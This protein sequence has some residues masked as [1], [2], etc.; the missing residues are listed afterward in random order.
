M[1]ERFQCGLECEMGRKRARKV[2]ATG[3]AETAKA[4]RLELFLQDHERLEAQ[5][6]KRGLNKASTAR[7]VI[8]EWLEEQEKRELTTRGANMV[9][10]IGTINDGDTVLFQDMPMSF[11]PTGGVLKGFQGEFYVPQGGAYVSPGKSF[12]LTVSDGRTGQI[13]IKSTHL[14]SNQGQRVVF[15]TQGQFE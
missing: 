7:M 8:L 10:D 3:Q 1:L 2:A 15:Q 4:I 6:R 11:Q 13:L 5:A 14:G 9:R 12:Q